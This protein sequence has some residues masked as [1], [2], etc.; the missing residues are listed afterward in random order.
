MLIL[1][2][3]RKVLH[4]FLFIFLLGYCFSTT[5]QAES[6]QILDEFDPND[7]A[8]GHILIQPENEV[9]VA[10]LSDPFLDDDPY[11]S[12]VPELKDPFESYNRFMH[13]INDKIYTNVVD[14]VARKYR[15][16]VNEDIRISIG[17]FFNN[18]TSP[19][20]ILS[21][22]AQGNLDKTAR[23]LGRVIINTTIGIGGFFD[24]AEKHFHIEDVNEDF[25]QALGYHKVPSGPYFVIPFLGPSTIRDI[26]GRAADT[27]TSF[28]IYSPSF[29]IGSGAFVTDKVNNTSF[30]VDDVKSLDENTV[31][32]YESIRDF[33]HQYREE[34]IR[35]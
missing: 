5:T 17:N 4:S 20:K 24:V 29:A 7:P 31:D 33:Y 28:M 23:A 27:V 18:L 21:S 10:D 22:L 15:D 2:V 16:W 19:R 32:K 9:K 14:P 12:S 6:E 30:I 13:K 26:V 35:K 3:K 1:S 34:L 8:V 11:K 25:G